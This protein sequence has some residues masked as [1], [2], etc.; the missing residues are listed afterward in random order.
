LLVGEPESADA[1]LGEDL[2]PETV[3]A[4]LLLGPDTIELDDQR[5]TVTVKVRDIA[6]A[7]LLAAAMN[8]ESAAA[9]FLPENLFFRRLMLA[10]F[11]CTCD[12]FRVDRLAAYDVARDRGK[13]SHRAAGA[14]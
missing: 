1:E 3:V 8:P 11:A 7:E 14:T 10:K 12:L 6:S 13:N 4:G 5:S 9:E 2:V